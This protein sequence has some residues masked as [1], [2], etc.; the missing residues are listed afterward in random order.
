MPFESADGGGAKDYGI[1]QGADQFTLH[2]KN[3]GHASIEKTLF[4]VR[5]FLFLSS[6]TD[7]CLKGK[8]SMAATNSPGL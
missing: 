1:D 2:L 6:Q 4:V 7:I 5:V 8:P 3:A